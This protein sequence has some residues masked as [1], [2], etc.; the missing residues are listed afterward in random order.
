M[1]WSCQ[2]SVYDGRTHY[3]FYKKNTILDFP[4]PM[5]FLFEVK[6]YLYSMISIGLEET[7]YNFTSNIA[8]SNII[9]SYFTEPNIA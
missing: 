3:K 1:I 7:H 8:P 6:C 9:N 2:F 4:F 5:H